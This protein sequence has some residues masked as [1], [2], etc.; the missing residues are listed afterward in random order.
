MIASAPRSC[1]RAAAAFTILRHSGAFPPLRDFRSL[2]GACYVIAT[3]NDGRPWPDTMRRSSASQAGDQEVLLA[4]IQAIYE[5]AVNP[6]AWPATLTAIAPVF[7]GIG[8]VLLFQRADQSTGTVV[9]PTL[10]AAQRAY[11]AG[12]WR[13]DICFTRIHEGSYRHEREAITDQYLATA[14]ER[15][16]HPFF[17]RFL[18]PHGLGRL[19]AIGLAPTRE[20]RIVLSTHRFIDKPH[21]DEGE[22]R[23]LT[24]IARHVENALR[25]G[26]RLITAEMATLALGEALGGVGAAVYLVDKLGRPVFMNRRAEDLLGDAFVLQG[27]RLASRATATQATFDAALE[28]AINHLPDVARATPR[29][30][31]LHGSAPGEFVAAYVQPAPRTPGDSATHVFSDVKAAVVALS[32]KA[33][34]PPEP[35]LVRDLLGVTL[36]EARLAALVSG[37][38][39]TKE[40]ADQLGI[41]HETARSAL[42]RVFEKTGVSRQS[43]LASLLERLVLR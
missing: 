17:T 35:T 15:A 23:T 42:K 11:E 27:K 25:L 3:G 10:E 9:S 32:S 6:S 43:E 1:R 38:V 33:S 28:T 8:C 26:V 20:T 4:A 14:E 13:D 18:I 19:A 21:F 29:P 24:H 37:G 40:A 5:A 41:A 16:D 12:A 2:R 31:I 34:E 30:I 22:L 36:S 7:G 39:T